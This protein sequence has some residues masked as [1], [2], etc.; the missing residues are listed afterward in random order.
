MTEAVSAIIDF[1][2]DKLKLQ[3]IEALIG[4]NN[5]PSLKII[6]R[7]HFIKEGHLRKHYYAADKYEDSILFS[8]LYNEY[9]T[10]KNDKTTNR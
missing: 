4:V 6:E 10:K 3:R 7:H 5:I 1:G 8:I 9:L 2:F